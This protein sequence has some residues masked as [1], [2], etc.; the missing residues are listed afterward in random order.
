MHSKP[1]RFLLTMWAQLL[2]R[3]RGCDRQNL[4]TAERI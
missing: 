2:F 4:R 3:R 1:V